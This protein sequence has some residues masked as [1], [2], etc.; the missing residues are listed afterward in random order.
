MI[1]KLNFN[2]GVIEFS[3]NNGRAFLEA[4]GPR[5]ALSAARGLFEHTREERI[6]SLGNGQYL[7][8]F[9]VSLDYR[10]PLVR[11]VEKALKLF[12]SLV[13]Y[14]DGRYLDRYAV[15]TV[16]METGHPDYLSDLDIKAEISALRKAAVVAREVNN[17]VAFIDYDIAIYNYLELNSKE[18]Y[19]SKVMRKPKAAPTPTSTGS[20]ARLRSK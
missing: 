9:K 2:E 4:P 7:V 5:E 14:Q 6:K 12:R 11:N 17:V 18:G 1:Y 20:P 16:F 15:A 3:Q 13:S 8:T 19:H 10:L